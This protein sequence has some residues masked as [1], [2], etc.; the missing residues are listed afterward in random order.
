MF[1][2]QSGA[3][4]YSTQPCRHK[5]PDLC[6]RLS[7]DGFG[8]LL[9]R[10]T[11]CHSGLPKPALDHAGFSVR[12]KRYKSAC[13]GV[14][15][16][17]NGR[18]II[19][20]NFMGDVRVAASLG[21]EARAEVESV[22]K[23]AVFVRSPRLARL[24]QYLCTKYFAGESDQIKEYHIA[25][26][27]LERPESFD[28]A[29]DAIARVEV[30]RLRKR[31][32]EYY[33]TEG[34]DHPLRIVIAIGQYAPAFV[35]A[36]ADDHTQASNGSAPP[37]LAAFAQDRSGSRLPEPVPAAPVQPWK[38][39]SLQAMGGL[40]L[41]VIVLFWLWPRPTAGSHPQTSVAAASVVT[42]QPSIPPLPTAMG[43]EI[44]IL[45]GQRNSHT[46]PAGRVWAADRYFE[47]GDY[48]ERPVKFLARTLDPALFQG[49][50]TGDFLY[51]IPLR[52][53][54]YELHLYF[55]E[56]TFGPGT[57]SGG[58][59]N[60]RVFHVVANGKRILSDFD[61]IADAGGPV[62]ADERVF[63]DISPGPDGLLQLRFV[64]LRSQ[65]TVSAIA[66]EPARPRTLNPVRISAQEKV[67]SDSRKQVWMPDR[68]WSGGQVGVGSA[69]VEGTA[70]PVLY[71]K[72]RYGNF[73][74][75][76]PVDSG[77]YA[78]TLHFAETYWGLDNPGGG[79]TG[80]RVFDVLCNGVALLRNFDIYKDAG[81]S[82]ALVKTFHGLEPNAQGKLL[83]SFVPVKNYASIRAI[84]VV[85]ESK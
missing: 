85:D 83:L 5:G 32:R 84:E 29:Q 78:V 66:L 4:A 8:G 31:L 2:A 20:P 9:W 7:H 13:V 35:P 46:D 52:P 72:E 21:E 58:G 51:R 37:A 75:A 41:C 65:A 43:D 64:S 16:S 82:R 53:G 67:F 19:V 42:S 45:C 22:L 62:I 10:G 17:L 11:G 68:F 57:T 24:L 12:Y 38:Y 80:T 14:E 56:T 48:T 77:K 71:S 1:S 39:W 79:G 28:P 3:F 34:A 44:R 26:E 55:A 76:I 18:A 54:V 33:E 61:I 70:D 25:V 81:G 40:I 36:H 30:H 73:S 60:S 59:E 27:V 6:Y 49:G 50:R 63:K 47:L 15:R 23:S 74:Y 69:F